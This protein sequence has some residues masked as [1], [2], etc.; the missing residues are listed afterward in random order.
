MSCVG[1]KKC[2]AKMSPTLAPE[3]GTSGKVTIG[4]QE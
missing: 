2:Q 4:I 3:K 1:V